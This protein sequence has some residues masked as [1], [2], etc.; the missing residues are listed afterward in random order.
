MVAAINRDQ[1]ESVYKTCNRQHTA[2]SIQTKLL[3]ARTDNFNK[4]NN[5][6]VFSGPFLR[7]FEIISYPCCCI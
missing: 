1:K 7:I 2:T 3:L 4:R 5:A 6:D